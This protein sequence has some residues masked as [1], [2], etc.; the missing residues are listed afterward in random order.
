MCVWALVA[1]LAI[2][3]LDALATVVHDHYGLHRLWAFII[4]IATGI[5]GYK[6][7]VKLR[8]KWKAAK[9]NKWVGGL[10]DGFAQKLEDAREEARR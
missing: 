6:L 7:F 10:G 8:R 4:L 3:C 5:V 9:H 1:S 2:I